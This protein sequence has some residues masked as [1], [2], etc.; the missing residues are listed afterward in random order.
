MA[1]HKKCPTKF[2]PMQERAIG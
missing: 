2:N 1:N